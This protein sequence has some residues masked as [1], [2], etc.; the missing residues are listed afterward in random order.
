LSTEPSVLVVDDDV[1]IRLVVRMILEG[2]GYA[3]IEA[4]DGA[5]ALA[6]LR[7]HRPCVILLDLMMPGVDGFQFRTEQVRDPSLSHIPV[8]I[9]SGGGGV[10][11]KAAE[12]GVAGHLAKPPELRQLLAE[13][14]RFCGR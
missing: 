5:E 9:L 12:L 14:A 4:A 8:V 3:V 1:D 2:H 13:V 11:K 6:R 7:E 10:A